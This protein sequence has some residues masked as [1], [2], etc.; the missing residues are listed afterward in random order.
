MIG[1]MSREDAL[2]KAKELEVDL[3]EI[4]PKARP[5]LCRLIDYGKMLYELK[6]KEA[7]IKLANKAKEQKGIR[8][9]FKIDVGDLDRQRKL[10]EKF[11][12]D[13]H[14]VR[15]Q[16]R[17]RGRERAHMPMATEKM[18]EFLKSLAEISK[19]DSHPKG[20]GAQVIAVI[21]PTK[22]GKK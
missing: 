2:A 17:L 14:A 15:I 12:L 1:V 18:R 20:A 13:G 19:V 8:L 21:S 3:V 16:M 6:K 7:K 4:S 22:S 5:P 10:A 11:L 9:T